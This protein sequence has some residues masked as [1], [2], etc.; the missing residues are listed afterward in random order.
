MTREKTVCGAPRE[1]SERDANAAS[2]PAHDIPEEGACE[3]RY[4]CTKQPFSEAD[5]L[6]TMAS[7]SPYQGSLPR[8]PLAA[9][10][11]LSS[12]ITRLH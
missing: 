5:M 2:D 4:L 1:V 8:K 9:H 12:E 11:L 3:R 7:P 10:P 6:L